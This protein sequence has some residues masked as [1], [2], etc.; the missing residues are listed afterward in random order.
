M[1]KRV[2]AAL[3]LCLFCIFGLPAQAASQK[4][5]VV[6][7]T[8]KIY[9]KASTS[10]KTISTISYGQTLTRIATS[11]SWAKVKNSGGKIGYCKKSS[12]SAK[13]PN[14]LNKTVY[15]NAANTKVYQRPSTSSKVLMKLKL[16][17]KY[18][19]VARTKDGKWYRLKNGGNYGYVQAKSISFS[20]VSAPSKPT[21]AD[22]IAALA[23]KQ[24]GKGYAYGAEGASKFDCSGLTHY[25]YKHAAG[26]TLRRASADQASD[27]RYKKITSLS[28]LKKGDLLC[29]DT[30]NGGECD[31]VG[32]YIG[33]SKFVHAS[34]SKSRVVTSSLTDYW[35]DAF[36]CA[37]RIV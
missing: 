10:S 28:S 22:K 18:K 36:L 7:N 37:R 32:V 31:H 6:A 20:A 14:T 2:I 12:L 8:L 26:K 13:N 27:G 15:I 24:V 35:K 11:G 17:S 1:K 9:K 5:Y 23:Q 25:V 16:N 33:G 29:F 34:Q 4:V 30:G 21:K 3:M 19:A